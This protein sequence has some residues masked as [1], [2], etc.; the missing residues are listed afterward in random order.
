MRRR[1]SKGDERFTV[2]GP[3][4]E[5]R[6]AVTENAGISLAQNLACRSD[7]PG[8]WYV[9]DWDTVTYHVERNKDGV[10]VTMRT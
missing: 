7:E 6:P 9:R 3:G 2:S 5:G 8:T 4:M 10:V 1:D